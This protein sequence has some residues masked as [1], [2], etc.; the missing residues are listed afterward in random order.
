MRQEL[1]ARDIAHFKSGKENICLKGTREDLRRRIEDWIE[2]RHTTG[3]EK[4]FWLH[5]KAGSGKSAVANTVAATAQ[6]Q[7]YLLSCFFCKRDDGY[8]SN[9]RN[10]LPALAFRFAQQHDSYR[11]ALMKL[12]H[13]GTRGVGIV[14]TTD[15]PTQLERLFTKLLPSI[16]DP[17]RPHVIVVDALD[18]SGSPKEQ[19]E[20]AKAVLELSRTAPWVKVFLTSRDEDGISKV[21]L[22]AGKQ[23]IVRDINQENDA[24]HDIELYSLFQSRA[25]DLQLSEDETR[26]LVHRA[27]GL[28]IWCSTL[29]RYLSDLVDPQGALDDFFK[30]DTQQG[31]FDQLHL[32]Y[33]QVLELAVKA[34]RDVVSMRAILSIISLASVNRPLS[35][36]AISSF[37][38]GY[39]GCQPE[40]RSGVPV[41]NLVKRLHAVLYI[42]DA[43][44]G[45]VRAYHKSFYD[46]LDEQFRTPE[47][48][49]PRLDDVQLQM[50]RRSLAIMRQEL[51]FNICQLDSPVLNENVADLE[52]RIQASVSEELHYGSR[53][54]FTHL[55]PSHLFEQDIH[56]AVSDL[57]GTERLLFWLECLSLQGSLHLGILGLEKASNIFK[58]CY[59]GQRT[60]IAFTKS[61][62]IGS[63][64][65]RL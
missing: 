32:L 22:D 58:V 52:N 55:L 26:L 30:G 37:L 20:L 34:P 38:N 56:F 39:D 11:V 12:F 25:L 23:C 24:D 51:R 43:E 18:E 13:E 64:C 57:F 4:L 59:L 40:S 27:D 60:L 16:T 62:V 7:D 3:E 6:D 31:S 36:A 15:I 21:V 10:L 28:F 54:W 53:F 33:R 47:T 5:G 44:N 1:N 19:K 41:G 49:W 2:A 50:L 46:F 65:G 17:C 29:F 42:Q 61:L 63:R 8:L 48:G 35:I 45:V 14:E 9:P